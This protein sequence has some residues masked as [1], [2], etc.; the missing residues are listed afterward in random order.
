MLLRYMLCATENADSILE[1]FE[2]L[3]NACSVFFGIPELPLK[4]LSID[5]SDAFFKAGVAAFPGV[6]V[7]TCWPLAFRG[8]DKNSGKLKN[9]S[10]LTIAKEH[11]ESMHL[12]RTKAQMGALWKVVKEVP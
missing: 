4:V 6:V 7:V 9:K 3:K 11:V 5:H 8:L 10:F 2:C 12:C 1:G